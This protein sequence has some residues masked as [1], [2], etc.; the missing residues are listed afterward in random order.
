MKQLSVLILLCAA[1]SCAAPR[2]YIGENEEEFTKHNR[3]KLVEATGRTTVYRK[4]NQ[5][6]GAPPV[7]KF[8]YFTDGKL[9]RVDEG[10]RQ[11]DI[12]IQHNR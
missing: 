1:T 11:P 3:V 5:P 8:F 2:F 4:T 12:L 7:T 10:E 6:F 9:S